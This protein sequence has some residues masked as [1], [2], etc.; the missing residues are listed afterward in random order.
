M[1]VVL[2]GMSLI[3]SFF[4]IDFCLLVLFFFRIVFSLMLFLICL[5]CC[6]VISGGEWIV[7]SCNLWIYFF[8]CLVLLMKLCIIMLNYVFCSREY[9]LLLL[10]GFVVRLLFDI[11]IVSGC[12][13]L[14]ILWVVSW[15]LI[16]FV[17]FE[18]CVFF[19]VMM[20]FKRCF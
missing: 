18:V 17:L 3:R 7:I 13:S 5:L 4:C 1:L 19:R 14:V 20:L 16:F 8:L 12:R 15:I 10:I 2:E 6:F 9:N 11:N